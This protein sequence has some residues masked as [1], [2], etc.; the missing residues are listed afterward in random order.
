MKKLVVIV[1][2]AALSIAAYGQFGIMQSQ[3]TPQQ[4]DEMLASLPPERRQAG[5][6]GYWQDVINAA[7]SGNASQQQCVLSLAPIIRKY[8]PQYQEHLQAAVQVALFMSP[9][10]QPNV[11]MPMPST[12]PMPTPMP[13]PAIGGG[14][15]SYGGSG[16]CQTCYGSGSCKLCHGTGTYSNYGQS[17]PCNRKCWSCGGTGRR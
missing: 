17:V 9:C 16:T 15:G 1:V 10:V 13:M 11:S 8:D 12:M 14:G 3:I 4:I 2:L 7:R 6:L 5:I